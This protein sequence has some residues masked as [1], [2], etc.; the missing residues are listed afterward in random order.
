[1][2]TEL[3]KEQ[4]ALAENL[5]GYHLSDTISTAFCSKVSLL[6]INVKRKASIVQTEG[7]AAMIMFIL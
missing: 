6:P 4:T 1:V 3:T 5:N 2:Q 7:W